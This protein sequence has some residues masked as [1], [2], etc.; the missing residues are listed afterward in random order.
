[1]RTIK[2]HIKVISCVVHEGAGHL[3]V[4]LIYHETLLK[5]TYFLFNDMDDWAYTDVYD[6][7]GNKRADLLT[8]DTVIKLLDHLELKKYKEVL[9]EH[10][11]K[12]K[13]Y[14]NIDLN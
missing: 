1:M 10:K 4:E 7:E 8:L 2:Q 12:K 3:D 6:I 13:G 14:Y 9:E 11:E 5:T